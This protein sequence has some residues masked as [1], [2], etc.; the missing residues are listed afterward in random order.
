M[1][2]SLP[3]VGL[4]VVAVIVFA[5]AAIVATSQTPIVSPTNPTWARKPNLQRF[6]P[7]AV[8]WHTRATDHF[9]I[10][11]TRQTDLDEIARDA[12]RAYT[13]LS[14][15]LGHQLAEKVPLI[16]LPTNE[17]APRDRQ[18]AGALVRASGAPDTD[19]LLL[20]V[21][22]RDGRATALLHELSH[23]FQFDLVPNGRVPQWAS[24]GFADHET[25]IWESSS[26]L[27]VRQAATAG[28]LPAVESLVDSDRVWGHALFDF[29]A[30]TYGSRGVQRYLIA[31]RNG[32]PRDSDNSRAAFDVA[33]VDFNRAFYAYVRTRLT[34]RR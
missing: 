23:I 2:R 25:A 21:E 28:L 31:L 9:D 12:E 22:P 1:A 11:H 16:L 8:V 29:V 26:L 30:A 6:N 19:H 17:D 24:E 15:D 13:R 33:A 4:T 3:A 7:T 5:G 18:E 32:S 27:K 14:A 20:P 34:E 10:Y